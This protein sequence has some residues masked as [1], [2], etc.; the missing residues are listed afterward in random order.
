MIVQTFLFEYNISGYKKIGVKK[1]FLKM[2]NHSV[3]IVR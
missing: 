1:A 3:H 2:E